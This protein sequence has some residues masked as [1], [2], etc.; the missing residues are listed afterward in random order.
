[1][2]ESKIKYNKT[3]KPL[4]EISKGTGKLADD[5]PRFFWGNLKSYRRSN[6][7][8]ATKLGFDVIYWI[9]ND[10]EP[11]RMD[12]DY[13]DGPTGAVSYFPAGSV[14][15]RAGT[16]VFDDHKGT[17]AFNLYSSHIRRVAQTVGMKIIDY[18]DSEESIESSK[19]EPLKNG[20]RGDE[21]PEE[22][23][24]NRK[25]I[26]HTDMKR[27]DENNF[28]RSLSYY[29]NSVFKEGSGNDY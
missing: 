12:T 1:M 9:D 4:H 23:S 24:T 8:M 7:D 19:N 15:A 18:V 11:E 26:Q 22:T 6:D 27:V 28:P 3:K 21:Q 10:Q 25:D 13:P 16:N 5:G 2:K 14:D 29:H 20:Q 17:E